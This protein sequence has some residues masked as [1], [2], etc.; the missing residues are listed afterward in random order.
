VTVTLPA[1]RYFLYGYYG[2]SNLGDDLLLQATI[3]GIRR[4]DPSAT[5]LVRN[6]GPIGTGDWLANAEATGIDGIAADQSLSRPRRLVATLLA[7]WNYFDRCSWLV[8]GGGTVFHERTSAFPIVML[9]LI[10]LLARLRGLR[11]AALGVGVAELRS[12]MG[13]L[14]LRAIVMM[15]E[16]FAVRDEAAREQCLKAGA[17]GRVI[18]TGDLVF[19]LSQF[20][21]F[22]RA[23]KTHQPLAV[24]V[25]VSPTGLQGAA[26]E[27]GLHILHEFVT[28]LARNGCRVIL[29]SF[30]ECDAMSDSAS[31]ARIAS[32]LSPGADSLVIET[33]L[34]ANTE[35]IVRAFSEIDVHCGMRFHGH[36]LAA[37]FGLPFVGI[38][39][40][41]KI[42]Q[43]CRLFDMPS[44]DLDQVSPDQLV[45]AVDMVRTRRIAR[46]AVED[47]I[48]GAEA[49]FSALGDMMARS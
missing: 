11:L 8:F 31:L 1:R 29:L 49:N 4:L 15:S 41:N 34:T 38:S 18:L 19:G 14:A 26:G 36:V 37:M 2:Q 12:P 32:G 39:H 20:A 9:A 24:A 28:A 27:R 30:Q 7:Y 21:K 42:E 40:D 23:E 13:R 6:L 3:E 5:F 25:S 16:A 43:I 33:Q 45:A 35:Q 10:S 46:G 22:D 44:Y 47:C 48:A 17:P